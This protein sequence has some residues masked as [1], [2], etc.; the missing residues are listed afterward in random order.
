MGPSF[1]YG[2]TRRGP[3]WRAVSLCGCEPAPT[4]QHRARRRL[5]WEGIYLPIQKW[6]AA[7]RLL[8][9]GCCMGLDRETGDENNDDTL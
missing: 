5:G 3:Y 1:A 6:K 9:C 4:W 8:V 7:A 2:V